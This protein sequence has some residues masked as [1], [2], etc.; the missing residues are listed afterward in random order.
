MLCDAHCLQRKYGLRAVYAL[1]AVSIILILFADQLPVRINL[2]ASMPQGIYLLSG[3]SAVDVG[4]FVM[5]CLNHSLAQ[6]ALQRRYLHRGNCANGTQPLLKQ[7]V[8]VCGD[9]VMLLTNKVV[10][11]H[12][13]LPHSATFMVDSVNRPLPAIPRGLYILKANQLWLYGTESSKSWDS[14]YFGAVDR[15]QVISVVKPLLIRSKRRVS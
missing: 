15:S 5:V 14:R 3:S 10:I 9:S 12:K 6:F 13:A 7:V 4:D 2:S 1:I 8:A 11:H